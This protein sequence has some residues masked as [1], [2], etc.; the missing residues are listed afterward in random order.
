MSEERDRLR[1]TY[2]LTRTEAEKA[3]MLLLWFRSQK[4][5]HVNGTDFGRRYQ[6]LF[7]E[8]PLFYSWGPFY[9]DHGLVGLREEEQL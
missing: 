2:N 8:F 1:K 6:H 3:E 5:K 9:R 7:G 4:T